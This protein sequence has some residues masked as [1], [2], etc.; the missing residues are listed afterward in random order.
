MPPKSKLGASSAGGAGAAVSIYLTRGYL[1]SV[2]ASELSSHVKKCFEYLRTIDQADAD[3]L[4]AGLENIVSQLL[5]DNLRK[6]KYPTVRCL[7]AQCAVEILRIYVPTPPYKP[8]E[9]K[10]C[11]L[12]ARILRTARSALGARRLEFGGP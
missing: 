2:K 5:Q 11:A 9:L 12:A 4:P 3:K 6:S 1:T 10:V 8:N 7:T